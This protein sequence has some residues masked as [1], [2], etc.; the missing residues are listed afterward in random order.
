MLRHAGCA[1]SAILHLILL[2]GA[3][4]LL[5]A[6]SPSVLAQESSTANISGTVTGPRGASVSGADVTITNKLTGQATHTTTSPAGTYAVRD[7]APGDYVIH[8]EA[9]GFQPAELLVRIQSGAS[10]TGDVRLQ[11]LA[12]PTVSLVDTAS[13]AVRGSETSE[14]MEQLPT[15]RSFVELGNLQPGVQV[16]DGVALAPAKTA[17]S[18][19]SIVGR[20]GRTT[21]MQADGL[22]ITEETTGATTQNIPVSGV[23]ELQV[24]QSSVPPPSALGAGGVVNIVTKSGGN[25]LRGQL[26]GNARDKGAGIANFLGGQANPYS[27][28][29]F[30]GNVGGPISKDKL[31]FF[32]GGEY[33]KQDL[34]APVVFNVPFTA[35]DGSY[36]SPFRDTELDGRLDYKLS[37]S[38]RLFYRFNYDNL[39]SVDSFGGGNFQV[40]KTS[41]HAPTH[42]VG[43]DFGSGA[44]TQSVRFGYMRFSN[45]VADAVNGSGIPNLAPGITLNFSGG[46][47]FASGPSPLAL[48]RTI[49]GNK[50]FRYDGSRIRHSHTFRYGFGLNKIDDLVLAN[51]YGL[52]P[53]VGL[54]TS[55]QSMFLAAS[56]PGGVGNPLSYRVNSIILGNG[57]SCL[58]EKS[59][60]GSACG[61]V[62]DTRAQA[63]A[64]DS[65]KARSNL[66]LT[67]GLQYVRD[68]GRSNSDLPGVSGLNTI[69]NIPGLG[70]RERQPNLNFAPQVGVAWDPGKSGRTVFRAGIGL[71]YDNTV[72]SN[73]LYDRVARLANG[74]FN[75]QSND[76]CAAH[77][78]VVVPGTPPTNTLDATQIC[79]NPVGSVAPA[80]VSLQ[81]QFQAA[82]AALT[83]NSTN[84]SAFAQTLSSQQGLLAPNFQTPRSVQMNLGF[85]KQIRQGT[86]FSVDYV[87]N[88]GTHYL[89]GW[90]TNHVGDA[91]QFQT[92]CQPIAPT[93]VPRNCLAVLNA[94]NSTIAANTLT[95]GI[96]PQATSAGSS[97]QT[98]VT[99]YLSTVPGASIVDFATHGLDSGAQFLGGYPAALFGLTPQTGAAFG[100]VNPAAG[101]V[102]TFFPAGRSRYSGLEF[103][104]RSQVASPF[105][106]PGGTNLQLSYTHASF[107]S[108]V[109]AGQDLLPLAADFN[110]PT[111]FFGSAEQDRKHQFSLAAYMDLPRGL[112]LGF[113][114]RFESPLPQTLYIPSSDL[115]G[116][117]FRS[118]VTG[119]GA[120]GGQSLTGNNSYGDILPEGNIG[121][122]GRS[123]KAS[124]LNSTILNFNNNFAGGLTAAGRDLVAANLL[125]TSQLQALGAIIPTIP[126]APPGNVGLSWL[127]SF[128][129]TLAWPLKLGER[130]T[131]EPRISGFNLFN[132]ANFDAPGNKLGGILNGGAGEVNGTT[133]SNRFATRTGPGSGTFTLGAPRQ[134][135]FGVKIRF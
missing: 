103:S 112:R 114:G 118:D 123:I 102:V 3:I 42:T 24:F 101:R 122:F 126:S 80:I 97:S 104:V 44:S 79:G 121:S 34:V 4:A 9:K 12:A 19:V 21:R 20:S 66:T 110:H 94:I 68:T 14:Q 75:A 98:A 135:E 52:A 57:I 130:F 69:G 28:E 100:G 62:S 40:F 64:Q 87:R 7:L 117:I 26:F 133:A 125:T 59:A 33:F 13:P 58:T 132:L 91:A 48:Q 124:N 82:Y 47:G 51:F 72:F 78:L 32:L 22:D 35:L 84:A 45:G 63:Y 108:N 107:H 76:P 23:Q 106:G 113:I 41:A 65:W 134:V 17:V 95:N 5:V 93:P 46:S 25:D 120:F 77:G 18:S 70:S 71:Y 129:L 111:A 37:G 30:G 29:V 6:I 38:A 60:F 96:C 49:Q 55:A 131:F 50:E 81:Q 11:R 54:D 36:H 10:V 8:V 27:R 116:E 74:R 85:Q 109:P 88:V 119:D 43:L 39:S 56:Q 105:R 73:V 31:F 90:D 99:C 115:P 128:D 53:E 89:L 127:R 83:P 61:G 67:Y 92:N 1:R 86:V 15:N 2:V 16:V